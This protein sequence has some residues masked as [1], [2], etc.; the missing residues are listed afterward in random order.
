MSDTDKTTRQCPGCFQTIT[1]PAEDIE[2]A[3]AAHMDQCDGC[4]WLWELG[5]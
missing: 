2:A 5:S 4:A 1:A 3:M